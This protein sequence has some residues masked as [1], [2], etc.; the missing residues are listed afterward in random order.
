[1]G[2]RGQGAP[3]GR[4]DFTNAT[5]VRTEREGQLLKIANRS[6]RKGK[7]PAAW[8]R[9]HIINLLQPGKPP[10]EPKSYRSISRTRCVGKVIEGLIQGRLQFVLEVEDK[11]D[12]E[13]AGFRTS[14]CTEER[15][16]RLAQDIMDPIEKPNMHRAVMTSVDL[17][18]AYDR[19]HR[20]SLLLKMTDLGIPP[21]MMT[22]FLN[23]L[24]DCRVRV[25]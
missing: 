18:A 6:M 8:R 22:W 10:D 3:S 11:L 12:P 7:V 21:W 20:A 5:G 2:G 23:F 15:M 13:Q 24:S 17:T 25:R 1:M 4:R 19:V 16:T 9:A 14:T